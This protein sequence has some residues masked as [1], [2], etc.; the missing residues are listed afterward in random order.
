MSRSTFASIAAV[1]S[2]VNG[3]PGLIAPA[4]VASLY[5]VTADA[6]T[7]LAGQLLAGSYIA[8]ESSIG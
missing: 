6:Q 7:A 2:L 3:V 5:G 8:T 4:A 1:V